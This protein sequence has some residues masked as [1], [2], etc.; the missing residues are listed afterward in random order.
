M[1]STSRQSTHD[2]LS[3]VFEKL[4]GLD[5]LN[6]VY[7]TDAVMAAIGEYT[8]DHRLS[9]QAG[10]S[11][12]RL[13]GHYLYE[14]H[15]SSGLFFSLL[16]RCYGSELREPF[17]LFFF[18][19]PRKGFALT[20]AGV[21][22]VEEWKTTLRRMLSDRQHMHKMKYQRTPAEKR[23]KQRFWALPVDEQVRILREYWALPYKTVEQKRIR[24]KMRLDINRNYDLRNWDLLNAVRHHGEVVK[25]V[26]SLPHLAPYF[27]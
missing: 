8:A 5:D 4:I 17:S 27:S 26:R 10:V 15:I 16:G 23:A 1:P 25:S 24:R 14:D 12:F 21:S 20:A 18:R 13:F 9:L 11:L 6:V 2:E 3:H 19:V 22:A 7:Y